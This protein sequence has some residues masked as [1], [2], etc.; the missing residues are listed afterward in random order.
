MD[1]APEVE[2]IEMIGLQD[3]LDAAGI[4]SES[5]AHEAWAY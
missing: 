1:D 5:A 2:E 3:R 4:M